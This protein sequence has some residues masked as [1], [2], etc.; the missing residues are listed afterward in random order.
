[1]QRVLCC[2]SFLMFLLGACTC[3][4]TYKPTNFNTNDQTTE[5]KS[6]QEFLNYITVRTVQVKFNCDLRENVVIIGIPEYLTD[7]YGDSR[8]SGTIVSST[9]GASYIFT[10]AHV[11]S[12]ANES[13]NKAYVCKSSIIRSKL[14]DPDQREIQATIIVIDKNKDFAV[15]RVDEDLGVNTELEQN[16]TLG[17][18]IWAIGY[19]VQL[20]NYSQVVLSITSGTLATLNV[21]SKNLARDGYFHRI[22]AQI[23]FGNSGGGVWT[24]QGKLVGIVDFMF[25]DPHKQL[26]PGYG[27]IKP[28]N[29]VVRKLYDTW[30]YQEVFGRS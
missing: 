6:E 5:R 12:L 3:G 15:L 29:E 8:G 23:Y 27:Y 11:V 14:A 26:S 7:S 10:A 1:M 16:P 20:Y 28:V 13:D 17:E 24:R 22:T 30:R 9:K 25:T 4:S 18:A 2:L 21:K 19:P